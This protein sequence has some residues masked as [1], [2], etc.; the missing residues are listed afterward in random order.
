MRRYQLPYWAANTYARELA[1]AGVRFYFYREGYFHPKALIIDG[2]ICSVGSANMDIRSFSINYEIN[3]IIYDRATAQEL[4]RDFLAD[5]EECEEFTW[6]TYEARN[7][8]L[9]FRDSLARLAS[10]LL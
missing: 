4:E 3:S 6:R 5:L 1:R 2:E 9:R 10:P 8:L 7:F